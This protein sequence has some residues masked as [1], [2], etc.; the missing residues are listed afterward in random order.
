MNRVTKAACEYLTHL[1]RH[2]G[3]AIDD[4]DNWLN[5]ANANIDLAWVV[6]Y[7]Y[8]FAF[9][10]LDF[11]NAVRAGDSKHLDLLWREFI[12]IGHA[13]TA[14]K[15]NYCPMAIMTI[16]RSFGCDGPTTFA[17]I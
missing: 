1:V 9:L 10:L 12:L 11:K 2:G 17:A 15:T 7:L 3:P 16:F 14:N 8:D 5:A 6:H 4:P 13:K